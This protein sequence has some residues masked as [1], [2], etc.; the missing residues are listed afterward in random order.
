MA[1]SEKLIIRD[2]VANKIF[3]T[4]YKVFRKEL[5]SKDIKPPVTFEEQKIVLGRLDDM[6]LQQKMELYCT[7][8]FDENIKPIFE[9]QL[10]LIKDMMG[11]PIKKTE[12]QDTSYVQ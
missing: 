7:Y 3:D 11:L 8:F 1:E 4:T 2:K 10:E 6:F 12:P 5:M 9:K